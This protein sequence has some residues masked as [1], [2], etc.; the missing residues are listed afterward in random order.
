LDDD[1]GIPG[2]APHSPSWRLDEI[3][4]AGSEHL[5]AGF[6]A[7]YER[8]SPTDWS[9]DVAVLL[10]LGVGTTSTLVDFGAGT[11]A[12]AHA[13]SPHVA[14]VVA[15]D[16]S[17]PMVE[18]TR[19]RGIEAVHAGFLDYEHEGDAPDAVFTR[20][21]LHHLPDFWKAMAL[22]RVSR[23]LRPGGVLLLRDLIYS[24]EPREA[25]S[26]VASW[27]A[28]APDDPTAGWTAAELAEHVREEHSTFAWLLEAMM[29]RV[30]FEIRDRWLSPS[31]MYGAYTCIRV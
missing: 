28:A 8:K 2:T 4:H 25:E 3:G 23:L 13:I 7:G 6:V 14:R 16:V 30:G 26:A 27:L 19:A 18:A 9:E 17:E 11:G 24:F 1:E 5:D 29:E 12:F 15:V 10:A 31:R 21:A 22:E 20:N